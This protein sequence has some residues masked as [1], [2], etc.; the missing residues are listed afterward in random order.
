MIVVDTGVLYASIDRRDRSHV[1][2]TEW[3]PEAT[4]PLVVPFAVLVETAQLVERRL[5]A[6]ALVSL[7]RTVDDGE[8]LLLVPD[9]VDLAR[10]A[11]LV[12]RYADLRLGL[13]DATVVALAERLGVA[14]IATLDRRH[15]TV[16]RPLHVESFNLVP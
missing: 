15:F 13:V 16:V 12:G 10:T 7:L 5:C 8:P 14:T 2:V 11:E 4:G 9:A 6:D 1:A 3:L